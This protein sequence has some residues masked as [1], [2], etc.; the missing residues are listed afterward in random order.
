M[1]NTVTQ[2]SELP[3]VSSSIANFGAANQG[4]IKQLLVT[5]DTN[6]TDLEVL[7][8]QPDA[9]WAIVGWQ[10]CNAGVHTVE[11]ASAD[12]QTLLNRQKHV[13]YSFTAQGPAYRLEDSP[14]LV[15]QK[16][17]SLVM[18]VTGQ[19]VEFLL[20]VQELKIIKL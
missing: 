5:F 7:Q 15:G 8:I 19:P 9:Y 4:K 2:V 18:Q 6:S 20:Y 16:G 13:K 3:N 1:A 17:K 11:I 10:G 14:I 12:K